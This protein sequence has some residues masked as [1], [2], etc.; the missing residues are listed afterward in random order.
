MSARSLTY[1]DIPEDLRREA[2]G[3]TRADLKMLLVNPTYSDEQKKAI[4]NQL[5]Q[6]AKWEAGTLPVEGV[7]PAVPPATSGF[8]SIKPGFR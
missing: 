5:D 7:T 8:G 1:L 2:A 3:R 6:L 4:Q